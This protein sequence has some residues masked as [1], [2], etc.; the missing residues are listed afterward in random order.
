MKHFKLHDVRCFFFYLQYY[1]R[2]T[3]LFNG[4]WT[5]CIR[6]YSLEKRRA[7]IPLHKKRVSFLSTSQSGTLAALQRTG[8]ET[9]HCCTTGARCHG[10]QNVFLCHL[11]SELNLLAPELFFLILAHSVYKMWI[12]QE[13]NKLEL[14]N[15]LHFKE[16]KTESIHHV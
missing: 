14:W 4:Y 2:P 3:L 7:W 11:K 1:E 8:A 6:D 5:I 15:K 13:P 10:T 16:K 12:I 9:P